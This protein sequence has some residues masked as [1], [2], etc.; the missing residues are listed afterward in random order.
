MKI[1]RSRHFHAFKKI[2]LI[3]P[4]SKEITNPYMIAEADTIISASNTTNLTIE[5]NRLQKT[6]SKITTSF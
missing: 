3:D 4:D 5:K 6:S 1:L 2:E